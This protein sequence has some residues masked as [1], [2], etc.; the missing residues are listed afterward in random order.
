MVGRNT[1]VGYLFL[2]LWKPIDD[3][4]WFPEVAAAAAAAAAAVFPGES[5][6]TRSGRY[7]E[8]RGNGDVSGIARGTEGEGHA[9]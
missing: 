6:G 2:K 7:C 3:L 5:M 9:K 1:R 8:W 4:S